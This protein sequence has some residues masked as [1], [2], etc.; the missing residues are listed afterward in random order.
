MKDRPAYHA[1][2][3]HRLLLMVAVAGVLLIAGARPGR[4]AIQ[5]IEATG[6]YH[7]GD[8]D[9]RI[10]GHRLA[11]MDAKRNALE[12]AGTYVQSITEV[13]DFQLTRDDIK[14]YTAG[15]IAV[16]EQGDPKWEMI[17]E[18]LRCTVKVK[19]RVDNAGVTNRIA[20]L[21]KDKEATQELR[22]ARKHT[23]ENE[24]KVAD[25]NKQLKKAKKGS[26]AATRAKESRDN[27]LAG[28]DAATLKA[29]A[30]GMKNFS[31]AEWVQVRDYVN[32]N[33]DLHGCMPF[34]SSKPA[35]STTADSGNGLLFVAAPAFAFAM[36]KPRRRK[37]S[38]QR[39]GDA[40]SQRSS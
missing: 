15:I 32:R 6:R 8:N 33:V 10:D 25:L 2:V 31:Q 18:S 22:D 9:T 29:Q 1:V 28:I 30:I 19:A 17:G 12:K 26:P 11:L 23:E 34:K 27:A 36:S 14:T 37:G 16:E 39:R 38:T 13:K 5:E 3:V 35:Q 40:E 21:R 7:L 4:A 20:T 24:R